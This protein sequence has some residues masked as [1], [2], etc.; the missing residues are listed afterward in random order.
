ML[1]VCFIDIFCD[2]L[3]VDSICFSGYTTVY[4]LHL[5]EIESSHF[6]V[7]LEYKSFFLL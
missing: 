3:I 6:S 1:G 7:I 4:I 2:G 5:I